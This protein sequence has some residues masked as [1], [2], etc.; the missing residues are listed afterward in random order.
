MA[1]P[2]EVRRLRARA[3]AQ[4]RHHPDQPEL[5]ADDRRALK[6]ARAEAFI[7]RLVDTAPPLTAGERARL[8]WL[9]ASDGGG[10]VDQGGAR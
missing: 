5:A 4:T 9:L 2:A 8:A 10:H 6:V 7:R 3:A 1:S